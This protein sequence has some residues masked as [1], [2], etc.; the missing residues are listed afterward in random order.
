MEWFFKNKIMKM[1]YLL[2]RCFLKSKLIEN[3]MEK[4]I[5]YKRN[6]ST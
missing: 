3:E 6:N 4:N 2:K 1:N 5:N